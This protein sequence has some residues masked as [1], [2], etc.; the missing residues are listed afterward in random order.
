MERVRAAQEELG[1]G[2][3][4]KALEMVEPLLL[5]TKEALRSFDFL[6]RP[7]GDRAQVIEAFCYARVTAILAL[8][9]QG[10]NA[11]MPRIREL[12]GEAIEVA[13]TGNPA[14]KVLCAAAE[15]LSRSGDADGAVWAV[16]NAERLAPE[17][18]YVIRLRGSV[19][20]MFP[21][22]FDSGAG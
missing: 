1:T 14:W 16:R 21:A 13:G 4:G 12:A 20:S 3:P 2:D 6:G 22:A 7:S 19:Q 9:S 18:D 11:A 5:E 10:A 15:M 8:E 17:E